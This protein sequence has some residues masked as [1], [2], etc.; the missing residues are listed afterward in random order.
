MDIMID[1]HGP[2]WL[3]RATR[4]KSRAHWSR[5]SCCSSKTDRA[6]NLDGYKRIRDAAHVPLAAGERMVDDLRPARADRARSGRRRQPT[7]A[8]PAA[9]RR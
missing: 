7:P 9:S 4:R 6:G 5:T 3:T 8:A 1:L 2:P